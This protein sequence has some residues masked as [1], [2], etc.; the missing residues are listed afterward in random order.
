MPKKLKLKDI[1]IKSFITTPEQATVLG[2]G[3][4]TACQYPTYRD[5]MT[6]DP[7]WGPQCEASEFTCHVVTCSPSCRYCCES[8]PC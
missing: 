2:G 1:K 3:T 4:V 7:I 6:C 8:D 5:N